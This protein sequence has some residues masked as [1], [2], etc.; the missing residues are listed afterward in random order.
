MQVTN[1]LQ[2]LHI[3]QGFM[4]DDER[5]S[6]A[7]IELMESLLVHNNLSMHQLVDH[8]RWDCDELLSRCRLRGE[9]MD[10]NRLFQLSQT[11]FGHCC[12]FN[13]RQSG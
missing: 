7:E 1:V 13:L 3:F 9:I 2:H 11:F 8:L 12:S 4:L 6:Q 10:C 5:F